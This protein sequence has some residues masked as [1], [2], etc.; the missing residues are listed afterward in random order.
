MRSS[1]FRIPNLHD[2][3]NASKRVLS[4][5]GRVLRRRARSI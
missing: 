5:N 3:K 4:N 2:S 1:G